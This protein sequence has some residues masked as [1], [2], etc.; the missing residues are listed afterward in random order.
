MLPFRSA[1][2]AEVASIMTAHLLIPAMDEENP[3][4]VSPKI[5]E[6]Q[7]RQKM[8]FEGLIVTDAL[9]M[10]G[11]SK[12]YSPSEIAIKA[13]KAGV[14]IL[15]MPD[16]PKVALDAIYNALKSGYIS[17]DR[18]VQSL[19]RIAQA[20]AKLKPSLPT[21]PITQELSKRDYQGL[22]SIILHHSMRQEG[23]IPI[24]PS[25]GNN[26]IVVDDWLNCQFLERQSPAVKLPD[27]LGYTTKL[28]DHSSL[29]YLPTDFS[30]LL[31]VFVRGNPFRSSAG[32]NLTAQQMYVKL[33]EHQKLQAV[34][35]YGS[36]YVAQWFQ[37]RLAG[38][39]PLI[40]TYG[41]NNL[42]QKMACELLF[43][44]EKDSSS[45]GEFTD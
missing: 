30:T 11:I 10:G 37:K 29:E 2:A 6:D 16:D 38:H 43:K 23:K 35:V 17:E 8:G 27:S 22:C 28:L 31:Q 9:I 24:V 40:F 44:P 14:D 39:T 20:K 34:I 12:K 13:V 21:K 7:L 4:T 3:A 19:A 33:I 42:A 45:Q 18:I 5:I 26:I 25:P 1:I 32:L 36:P 15:L 41:Q